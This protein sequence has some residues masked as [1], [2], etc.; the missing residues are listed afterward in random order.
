[1]DRFVDW[2]SFAIPCHSRS[3]DRVCD[4]MRYAYINAQSSIDPSN[5][6]GAVVVG[7]RK[8]LAVGWNRFPPR[9]KVTEERLSNRS[10]RLSL[11]VHAEEAAITTMA[12]LPFSTKGAVLCCPWAACIECAK[13]IA[14]A[15][16]SWVMVHKERMEL[17]RSDWR[18]QIMT[19]FSTLK[20]SGVKI[21][22][23]EGRLS[24]AQI[25]IDGELWTP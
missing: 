12:S 4:Y 22:Y 1:M 18:E 5:Q 24:V 16:F 7:E 23:I 17:T 10:I 3:H 15:Q 21:G 6:N 13:L 11:I 25:L 9:I 20:E 19:A 14:D 2:L 8:I